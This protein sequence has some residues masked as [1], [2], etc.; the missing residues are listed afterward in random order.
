MH[1]GSRF[2]YFSRPE[3]KK[4]INTDMPLLDCLLRSAMGAYVWFGITPRR[5]TVQIGKVNLLTSQQVSTD[6]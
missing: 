6:L 5:V 4:G 2:V 3:Y 1:I